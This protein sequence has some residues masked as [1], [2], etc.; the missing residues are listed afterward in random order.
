VSPIRTVTA[1]ALVLVAVP[2]GLLLAA[3]LD[4]DTVA[5]L[6]DTVFTAAVRRALDERRD[7]GSGPRFVM[8]DR[9]ML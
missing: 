2:F 1:A 5:A 8:H 9:V 7:G 3:D 6:P 4:A